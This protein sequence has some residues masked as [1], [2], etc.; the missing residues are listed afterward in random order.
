M[1]HEII[2]I[3]VKLRKRKITINMGKKKIVFPQVFSE[4]NGMITDFY[5]G[6]IR[7]SVIIFEKIPG[8]WYCGLFLFALPLS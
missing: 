4:W 1:F 8:L 6:F 2:Q 5:C 7:K 3:I